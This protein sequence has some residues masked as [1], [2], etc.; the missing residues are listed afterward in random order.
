[1]FK[2]K[3]NTQSASNTSEV[4]RWIIGQEIETLVQGIWWVFSEANLNLPGVVIL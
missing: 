4:I 1:M 2:E 3:V